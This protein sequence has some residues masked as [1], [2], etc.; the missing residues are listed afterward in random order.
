MYEQPTY[1]HEEIMSQYDSSPEPHPQQQYH[2]STQPLKNNTS[3]V[4]NESF[5]VSKHESKYTVSL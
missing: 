2:S 5:T 3:N 4:D 1:E